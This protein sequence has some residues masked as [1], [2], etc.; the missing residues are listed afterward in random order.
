MKQSK[1]I[2]AFCLVVGVVMALTLP[3]WAQEVEKININKASVEELAQLKR[4]GPKYAERIVQY[5]D[6]HGPFACPEDIMKVRG[7]GSKT[8]EANKG[9]I[10]V[11]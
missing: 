1:R 9:C 10:I 4:V 5:R 7:I 3:L 2:V 6:E 11:E 8:Y